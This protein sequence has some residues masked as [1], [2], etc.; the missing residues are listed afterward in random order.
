MV[1]EVLCII[2]GI[3]G[4]ELGVASST[5]QYWTYVPR[6]RSGRTSRTQEMRGD[7]FRRQ[8][9]CEKMG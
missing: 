5:L 8:E 3:V 2:D 9:W 1:I 7:Y 6:T 4:C